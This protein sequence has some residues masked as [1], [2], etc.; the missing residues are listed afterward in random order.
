[1]GRIN[2][3]LQIV[4]ISILF[5]FIAYASATNVYVTPAGSATG[6][7]PAGTGPAPNFTPSQFNSGSNWGSGSGQIGADTAIL[8]CGTFT[9]TAGQN[10]LLTMNNGSGGT[11]GHPITLTCDTGTNITSPQWG[12]GSGAPVLV[13]GLSWMILDGSGCT[14]QNTANGSGLANNAYSTG[15]YIANGSNL[16]IKNWT[17]LNI[18]QH[19]SASDHIGCVTSGN[20]PAG[21]LASD[22]SNITIQGNTITDSAYGIQFNAGTSNSGVLITRNTTGRCNQHIAVSTGGA[23]QAIDGAVISYNSMADAV[24][25]D[26][27]VTDTF[28]HN[29]VFVFHGS[30]G[31]ITNTVVAGNLITGDFGVND[32]GYIFFN[33]SGGTITGSLVYNNLLINTS[34]NGP[35][36]GFITSLGSG[37]GSAYNNTIFCNNAG[38]AAV[39][40]DN[41][42]NIFKNNI[43]SGC[44]RGISVNAGA[45]MTASDYNDIYNL[46]GGSS[47]MSYNGTD[48]ASVAAWTVGTGFDGNSITANPNLAVSYMLNAGSPSIG[49]AANLTSLGITGLTI[50]APQTFGIAYSCGSG[51]VSRPSSGAWDIG[52]YQFLGGGSS[53]GGSVAVGGKAVIH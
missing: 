53:F 38:F 17:V 50:G 37:S 14:V 11:S 7:C 40:L 10:N 27:G 51:C 12:G 16:I 52:A 46:S 48:Y 35:V 42:G 26:D 33:V 3:I 24:N 20:L 39:K 5:Q 9:G 34:S 1:M 18:C 43:I 36:N 49:S 25:W 13:N 32:T 2:G 29:G 22:S 15:I 45:S 8:I 44:V 19:T 47:V 6:N 21:I 31:T 23:G 41:S 4:L 30:G 28:H